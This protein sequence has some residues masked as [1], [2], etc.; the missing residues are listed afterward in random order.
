MLAGPCPQIDV[1][2]CANNECQNGATCK[3]GVAAYTCICPEGFDGD[4]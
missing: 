1:D 2:E 4:L 3:D